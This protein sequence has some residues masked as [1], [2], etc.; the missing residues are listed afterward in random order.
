MYIK[1]LLDSKK[2][3][4]KYKTQASFHNKMHPLLFNFCKIKLVFLVI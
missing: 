2:K 3:F 1:K 4:P